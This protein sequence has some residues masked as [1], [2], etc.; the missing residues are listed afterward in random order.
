[1]KNHFCPN[2]QCNKAALQDVPLES[3]LTLQKLFCPKCGRAFG[4]VT[5]TGKAAQVAP[6][7]TA[8]VMTSK[9]LITVTAAVFG[10]DCDIDLH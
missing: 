10:H 8:V 5:N 2:P 6:L 4:R 1:M 3:T 7:I 9:L